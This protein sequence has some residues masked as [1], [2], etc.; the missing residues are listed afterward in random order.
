MPDKHR[1][2]V[3]LESPKGGFVTLKYTLS[4]LLL[5]AGIQLHAFELPKTSVMLN[6][7]QEWVYFNDGD[8]FRVLTGQKKGVV[9]RLV[10]FNA[11]ESYGPVHAWGEWSKQELYANA[12]EATKEARN[13]SWHC[14]MQSHKDTYGR[15]LTYCD[16]LA[17]ALLKK[18]LVHAMSVDKETALPLYLSAQQE[19]IRGKKGMW[20]KGVPAYIVTSLHGAQES[21][22]KDGVYDRLVSTQ[23]GHSELQRHTREYESC[24]TVCQ[25]PGKEGAYAEIPKDE[26]DM[27]CMVY[28]PFQNRYGKEKATC[29]M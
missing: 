2:K 26:P 3:G 27:S 5:L 28:V 9:A 22:G 20:L 16:D 19:A 21:Q 14:T 6:G 17:L 7:K 24:Q 15:S 12:Q 10:G 8:T 18:G 11:L 13:G 23:D 1:A 25:K 4:L 29:L